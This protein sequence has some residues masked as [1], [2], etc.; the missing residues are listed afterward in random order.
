MKTRKMLRVWHMQGSNTGY[1]ELTFTDFHNLKEAKGFAK[2]VKSR[3]QLIEVLD[4]NQ[5]VKNNLLDM[6]GEFELTRVMNTL[7]EMGIEKDFFKEVRLFLEQEAK[8]EGQ[9]SAEEFRARKTRMHGDNGYFQKLIK[10][11]MEL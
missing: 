2:K 10:S 11:I 6:M 7:E 5:E 1:Q 4:D 3:V 8:K 9:W